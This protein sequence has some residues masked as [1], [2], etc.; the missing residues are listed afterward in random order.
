MLTIYTFEQYDQVLQIHVCNNV[1]ITMTPI[2]DNQHSA[3]KGH[4][5]LGV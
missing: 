3:M 1:T 2:M 4:K 5:T